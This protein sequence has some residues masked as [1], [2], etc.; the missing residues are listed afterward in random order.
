MGVGNTTADIERGKSKLSG[1]LIAEL[2]RVYN[3][4]P[5]WIYGL[6]EDKHLKQSVTTDILPKVI[7]VDNANKDNLVL[8]N[9]KAAAGY[10]QNISDTSWYKQLPAFDLPLPEFRNST[11]CGFQVEGG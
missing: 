10:P 11:Y 7:T 3:I 9:A 5:L 4:N 1:R 6:S 8:V 2:L